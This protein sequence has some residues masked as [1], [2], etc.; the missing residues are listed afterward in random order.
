M[1]YLVW[2]INLKIFKYLIGAQVLPLNDSHQEKKKFKDQLDKFQPRY[3]N[4]EP[5]DEAQA[6]GGSLG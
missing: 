6:Q 3:Q 4:Q 1:R 5:Q 2:V